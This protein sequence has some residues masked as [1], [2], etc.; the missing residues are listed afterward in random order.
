MNSWTQHVYL[1]P[2]Y[3][4][5]ALSCGGTIHRQI[6]EGQRVQVITI[7]AAPPPSP[8]F[9]TYAEK[10]HRDW[11]DPGDAVATRRREDEAA[12]AILGA[13]GHYL[14]LPDCIYRGASPAGPWYYN[15]D[16]DIF[17][18][19]HPADMALAAEITQAGVEQV[20]Q[21]SETVIYAPL[22][23]GHHVDHQLTHRAAWQLRAQGYHIIFYEDYPYADPQYPFTRFGEGNQYDLAEA[24]KEPRPARLST[25]LYPLEEDDLQAKIRSVA[26]YASQLSSL[27]GSE[28]AM[29]THLR[30]FAFYIGQDRPAE[31][32]WMIEA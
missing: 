9:S 10:L 16:A 30:N 15:S 12:L 2:H 32:F 28:A 29:A 25:H 20:P 26:A 23:V 19:V 11:G 1:S 22:G 18:Q 31:R 8:H 14:F 24:L 6:Q 7:C 27:F 5:A 13:A 3:D 17:G 4:D 21:R